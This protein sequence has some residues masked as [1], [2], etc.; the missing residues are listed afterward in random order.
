MTDIN[1]ASVEM[2]NAN[3]TVFVAADI[4]HNPVA[5]LVGGRE[6]CSQLIEGAKGG[7]LHDFRPAD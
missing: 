7:V 2:D 4:E 1:F 3:K 5:N 6:G